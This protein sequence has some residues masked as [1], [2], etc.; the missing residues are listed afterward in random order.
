M[1]QAGRTISIRMP[2][3]TVEE[4]KAL[5][6][7]PFSTLVRFA[8]LAYLER[9]RRERKG[10]DAPQERLDVAAEI[11]EVVDDADLAELSD[12]VG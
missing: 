6:G 3:G 2:E 4:L 12:D 7:Q 9:C 11:R 1:A 10:R 8:M 5:T